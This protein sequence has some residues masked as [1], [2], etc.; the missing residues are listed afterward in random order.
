[1]L[2]V[3]RHAIVRREPLCCGKDLFFPSPDRVFIS[4][5]VVAALPVELW[6]RI[7]WWAIPKMRRCLVLA[8]ALSCV[9]MCD[10]LGVLPFSQGCEPKRKNSMGFASAGV[11]GQRTRQCVAHTCR[12][13]ASVRASRGALVGLRAQVRVHTYVYIQIDEY[14]CTHRWIERV[15]IIK[16]Q[17]VYVCIA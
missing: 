12:R 2:G 9:L 8:L 4:T 17:Y 11:F 5:Q 3:W 1:M 14:K 13:Q 15:Q 6:C 10:S 7:Q 16:Y